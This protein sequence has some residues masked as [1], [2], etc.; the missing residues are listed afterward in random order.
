[1]EHASNAAAARFYPVRPCPLSLS[2]SLVVV[3]LQKPKGGNGRMLFSFDD[4]ILLRLSLS[5]TMKASYRDW[6]AF[7]RGSQWVW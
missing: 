2:L 1:M 4:R 6:E 3:T 7:S 5:A